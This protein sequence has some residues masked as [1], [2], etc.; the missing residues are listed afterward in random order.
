MRTKFNI[1][2]LSQYVDFCILPNTKFK[3]DLNKAS[4]S[5]VD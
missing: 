1:F 2:G 3:F 4:S 5:K